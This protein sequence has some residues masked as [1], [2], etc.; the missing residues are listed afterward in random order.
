[1]RSRISEKQR[2][3]WRAGASYSQKKVSH[4][5]SLASHIPYTV[6]MHTHT[7]THTLQNQCYTIRTAT[8]CVF[9]SFL[10]MSCRF[11][12][13]RI[14]VCVHLLHGFQACAGVWK[15]LFSMF[16]KNLI[17]T[18]EAAIGQSVLTWPLYQ[19][20]LS[21][22]HW[23]ENKSYSFLFQL[24]LWASVTRVALAWLHARCFTLQKD[25]SWRQRIS[26]ALQK[27]RVIQTYSSSS[28]FHVQFTK[29]SWIKRWIS[30]QNPQFSIHFRLNRLILTYK[31]QFN[32]LWD[33]WT[34]L[35][36][37]I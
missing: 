34:F 12:P 8:R 29:L 21:K 22:W 20:F 3:T 37:V 24:N 36:K 28:R 19:N 35:L 11:S 2:S 25:T 23:L 13:R 26:T 15:H 7:H 30:N 1:M 27:E 9:K 5:T 16:F 32:I 18:K 14:H 33:S 10:E 4:H 31:L 17:L 6:L